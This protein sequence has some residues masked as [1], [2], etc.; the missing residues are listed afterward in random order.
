MLKEFDAQK[1]G[2]NIR[3]WRH[4]RGLKTQRELAKICGFAPAHLCQIEKGGRVP[5]VP[6]LARIAGNLGVTVADLMDGC[7]KEG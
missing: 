6:A 2:D 5:S 7:V 3:I 4:K 1:L